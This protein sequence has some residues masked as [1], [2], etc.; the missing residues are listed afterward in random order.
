M[1]SN[2][3]KINYLFHSGFYVET[4]KHILI[5]DYYKDE[6]DKGEKCVKNG[7]VSEADLKS[8]K[9]IIVFSSHSHGDHFNPV[10]LQWQKQREDIIYV[11]SSEIKE[12]GSFSNVNKLS[13]YEELILDDTYIKA[14]GS[15]D[16]G[17]SFFV[18][19]DGIT[20]FHAGDLNWWY[21]WDDTKEDI[22]KAEKMFKDE[23][24]KM[25]DENIDIAFFPVDQRL[26]H[27]FSLG[28]EYFIEKLKP[29]VFIPMHFGQCYETI[30]RFVERIN[31]S[32]TQILEIQN[33]GQEIFSK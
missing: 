20:L 29:K 10:I 33:R 13:P 4:E 6:V 2:T 5:F 24:Y 14:Y 18:K 25:K 1:I 7:A 16:L 17:V 22:E 26:E 15:T 21:W 19:V 30:S 23:I 31:T 12:K 3:I 8:K 11:F 27:N 9:Q 28:A 32:S